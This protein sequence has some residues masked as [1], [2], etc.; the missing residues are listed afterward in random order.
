V[1]LVELPFRNHNSAKQKIERLRTPQQAQAWE[2]Y[3]TFWNEFK[4]DKYYEK[5][6]TENNLSEFPEF[7]SIS[8]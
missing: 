8:H 1:V 5:D 2:R 7:I 6:K 4:I 3:T